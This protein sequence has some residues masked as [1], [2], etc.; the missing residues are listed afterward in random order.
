LLV[1]VVLC[2]PVPSEACLQVT[3]TAY[4][5]SGGSLQRKISHCVGPSSSTVVYR[6]G[7]ALAF[8]G[9]EEDFLTQQG[10]IST[11]RVEAGIKL[12]QRGNLCWGM[13]DLQGWWEGRASRVGDHGSGSM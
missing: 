2:C 13:L 10:C 8:A 4:G 6:G 5:E 12:V 7:L 3:G 9:R 11:Q 1:A